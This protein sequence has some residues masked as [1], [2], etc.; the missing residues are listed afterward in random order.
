[1]LK[2]A[3]RLTRVCLVSFYVEWW[4]LDTPGRFLSFLLITQTHGD[5]CIFRSDRACTPWHAC[6]LSVHKHV[7]H[8]Q[9][10]FSLSTALL[11]PPLTHTCPGSPW[12][13]LLALSLVRLRTSNSA[14]RNCTHLFS[15]LSWPFSWAQYVW[16]IPRHYPAVMRVILW[17]LCD[18]SHLCVWP[19]CV[20]F[21]KEGHGSLVSSSSQYLI[22]KHWGG[23]LSERSH[24]LI[25]SLLL[26]V[27]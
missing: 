16:G 24:H 26:H 17:S 23:C 13:W 7:F 4:S 25:C 10:P 19:G 5:E 9:G 18:P 21:F 12:P 14:A 15:T 2:I 27:S 1:M 22:G 11:C 20:I 3:W 8:T 6:L